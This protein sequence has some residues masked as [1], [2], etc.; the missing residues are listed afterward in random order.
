MSSRTDLAVEQIGDTLPEGIHS[1][2]RGQ[3]FT[4]TEITIDSDAHGSVIGRGKGRYLT[5]A[6]ERL[7]Q[8]PTDAQEQIAEL[9]AELR[10]LL[11]EGNLLVVGLGNADITPDALGPAVAGKLLATRHLRHELTDAE[12]EFAAL[13]QLRPVS[14]IANGVLAQTGIET[15]ELIR[16]LLD[17]IQPAA[18]IAVDALA[19]S[20]AARLGTT[21][22]ISDA[23]IAPGSGVQNR[24]TALTEASLGVPV[25]AIGVPTVIDLHSLLHTDANLDSTLP[26][27]M[28]TPRDID[29]LVQQAAHLIAAALNLALQPTLTPEDLA[30]LC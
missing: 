15:A 1:V 8:M 4:I 29:R 2:T 11:P 10:T 9:T 18:I 3:A 7:S 28:V 16:S 14:V 19:C 25:F 6:C 22:Q 5:L 24:R 12:A 30:F 17:T 20:D 27:M 21:I 26:N 13:R 23:G